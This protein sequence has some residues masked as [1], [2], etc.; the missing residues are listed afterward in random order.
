MKSRFLTKGRVGAEAR[1]LL[2]KW[3]L[4]VVEV[5]EGR[6]RQVFPA[7]S[8]PAAALQNHIFIVDPHGNLM[9]EH[10]AVTNIDSAKALLQDLKRLL[11]ASRIG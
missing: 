10:Q 5:M 3:R 8:F 2:Q 6:L 9:L 1:A 4:E 7:S 11:R